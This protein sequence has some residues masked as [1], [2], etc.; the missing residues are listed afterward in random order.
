MQ[1]VSK[2]I[3]NQYTEAYMRY[4]P[5][6]FSTILTKVNNL[7]DASD[8][9]QE[10]FII[11]YE[12]F[13]TIHNIRAWL[14]GT[15]KNVVYKYYAAKN[16]DVDIDK[17]FDS[18]NLSYTNGFRDT[19]ILINEAIEQIECSQEERIMLDLIAKHNFSYVNVAKILGLTRRQVE[20]K[21]GQVVKR[22]MDNLKKKGIT[23][24]EEL[25]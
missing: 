18:I 1:Q 15:L 14:Y 23:D 19:R 11:L 16:Q 6:I 4:Y 3:L 13:D 25:L 24:I 10:V 17:L 20:Y 21:Y 8:L 2:R 5:Q 7:E 22:I 12:K 9:C